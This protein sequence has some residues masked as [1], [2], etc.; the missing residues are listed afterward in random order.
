MNALLSDDLRA[1]A[2]RL[3]EGRD[4]RTSHPENSAIYAMVAKA[5]ALERQVD[6][7]RGNWPMMA[8]DTTLAAGEETYPSREGMDPVE[9]LMADAA[10]EG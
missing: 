9:R 7:L 5:V 8:D 6:V 3:N 10:G 1:L 4:L 2:S